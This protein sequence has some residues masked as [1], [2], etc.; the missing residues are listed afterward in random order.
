MPYYEQLAAA[1]GGGRGTIGGGTGAELAESYAL[2]G[3][4]HFSM[5]NYTAAVDYYEKHLR[6]Y[7]RG[8]CSLIGGGSLIG[9]DSPIGSSSIKGNESPI[10]SSSIKGNR[11]SPRG[12]LI[13][14]YSPIGNSSL[15]GSS[16]ANSIHSPPSSS[17]STTSV[18][19][20]MTSSSSGVASEG[21]PHSTVTDHILKN[22]AA[23]TIY[24]MDKLFKDDQTLSAIFA[25]GLQTGVES[26]QSLK[27]EEV[28]SGSFADYA[29]D[30][31][32]S[33]S[34]IRPPPPRLEEDNLLSEPIAGDR[35]T[36]GIGGEGL[37]EKALAVAYRNLGMAH[38]AAGHPEQALVTHQQCFRIASSTTDNN[39]RLR[40][41]ALGSMADC[42]WKLGRRDEALATY[43]RQLLAAETCTDDD[44]TTSSGLE[45]MACSNVGVCLRKLGD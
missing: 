38:V 5:R 33:D 24:P 40:M 16:T 23:K 2:L 3:Y 14:S 4:T 1:I 7:L 41:L 6:L 20:H 22:P 44:T 19:D 34:V 18:G 37:N 12:S 31:P 15:I 43:R 11:S 27:D 39:Y 45:A 8:G 25:D 28:D 17:R 30:A 32:E 10:G 42:Q 21:V 29:D 36:F 35:H 9:G 26:K 13:G